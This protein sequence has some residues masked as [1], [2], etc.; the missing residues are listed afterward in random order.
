MMV[1]GALH[2]Q[3]VFIPVGRYLLPAD[4]TIPNNLRGMVVFSHGAGSNRM[5]PRNTLVARHLHQ[6]KF[7]TLLFDLITPQEQ[8]EYANQIDMALQTHR[9]VE[10]TKWLRRQVGVGDCKFGYFGASTGAGPALA[11][12]VDNPLVAAVVSRGGRPDLVLNLLPRVMAPTL[13]LVG[14]HDHALLDINEEAFGLVGGVKK[15]EIIP[16]ATHLFEEQ[17]T[18]EQV[19]T[20]ACDWFELY[21]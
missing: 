2:K 4:L 5:S 6:R 19:A 10:A 9:L 1:S 20:L 14:G 15:L 18:M 7:G 21:L 3:S 12:A 13:F 8:V 11:A 16:G 17:G